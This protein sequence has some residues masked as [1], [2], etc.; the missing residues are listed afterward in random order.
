[1]VFPLWILFAT[2]LCYVLEGLVIKS[3]SSIWTKTDTE[4]AVITGVEVLYTLFIDTVSFILLFFI[5]GKFRN[6][7]FK[8]PINKKQ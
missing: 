8:S 7:I 5:S 4:K 6:A 2:I 1:M 3:T